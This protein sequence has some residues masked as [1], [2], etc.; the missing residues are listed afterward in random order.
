MAGKDVTLSEDRLVAVVEALGVP[1]DAERLLALERLSHSLP[2]V[3]VV[4]MISRGKSTLVN[5]L[6]GVE[7]CPTDSRG[8]TVANLTISPRPSGFVGQVEFDNGATKTFRSLSRFK[9]NIARSG[10]TWATMAH[11]DVECRL[12]PEVRLVDTPGVDDPHA[13]A[14]ALTLD[15]RWRA[16]GASGAVVVT[17]Y[18]PGV[19]ASDMAVIEEAFRIFGKNVVVV[20]K[21]TTSAVEVSDLRDVATS[22]R[23][24]FHVLPHVLGEIEP[25]EIGEWGHGALSEI[26]RSISGLSVGLSE[27]EKAEAKEIR[28]S[29]IS[30]AKS[31]DEPRVVAAMKVTKTW[32]SSHQ[33]V[34]QLD[35]TLSQR[36]FTLRVAQQGNDERLR[37]VDAK[38]SQFQ[39]SAELRQILKN[40][41]AFQG[42]LRGESL[43]N[44]GELK[45]LLSEVVVAVEAG[46]RWASSLVGALIG[47]R[48]ADGRA[49]MIGRVK[50]SRSKKDCKNLGIGVNDLVKSLSVSASLSLI[51]D[52]QLAS[53]IQVKFLK[54]VLKGNH[55]ELAIHSIAELV[56]KGLP[57]DPILALKSL[58]TV[59]DVCLEAKTD[60]NRLESIS[61]EV[62]DQ[63]IRL[64]L[65][66]LDGRWAKAAD[67]SAAELDLLV[68]D[69]RSSLPAIVDGLPH[70]SVR[71]APDSL[72]QRADR[73][74][75]RVAKYGV[76]YKSALIRD[77]DSAVR[78]FAADS[79]TISRE[80]VSKTLSR[81]AD[82]EKLAS[83]HLQDTGEGSS[84]DVLNE[85]QALRNARESFLVN[86]IRWALRDSSTG[87]GSV[88][89]LLSSTVEQHPNVLNDAEVFGLLL[90]ADP[91]K[92]RTAG[93]PVAK[94]L[95]SRNV[96]EWAGLLAAVTVDEAEAVSLVALAGQVGESST[97]L[98]ILLSWLDTAFPD[99]GETSQLLSVDATSKAV[100]RWQ[101]SKKLS[102]RI[103]SLLTQGQKRLAGEGDGTGWSKFDAGVRALQREFS[104]ARQAGNIL[105]SAH[106]QLLEGQLSDLQ[107]RAA[108]EAAAEE[109][110][111]RSRA[112][113][114][115]N[116]V[117]RSNYRHELVL[118]LADQWV[119][120]DQSTQKISAR[121]VSLARQSFAAVTKAHEHNAKAVLALVEYWVQVREWELRSVPIVLQPGDVEQLELDRSQFDEF[122][123]L[124]S[125]RFG[126]VTADCVGA[127][128]PDSELARFAARCASCSQ[129]ADKAYLSDLTATRRRILRG[130]LP[131]VALL[132]A[133]TTIG[134][135][136]GKQLGDLT[137][138]ED[139]R[140]LQI[141]AAPALAGL[142]WASPILLKMVRLRRS[143]PRPP[144]ASPPWMPL[145]QSVGSDLVNRTATNLH[146]LSAYFLDALQ[147][148]DGQTR[149]P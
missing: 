95:R 99:V 51:G 124:V 12:P 7:I 119:G 76:L 120:I 21:S 67:L 142:L 118:Q 1:V 55:V 138:E 107:A 83:K 125:E 88:L 2:C 108:A 117:V 30:G 29:L 121:Q 98:E 39:S 17:A 4:G 111:K 6:V 15:S 10:D 127:F 130:V 141:I 104:K 82:V 53:P 32:S 86:A 54:S 75:R 66:S 26:E 11:A 47:L 134:P 136:R 18:P 137:V 16:S 133:S 132:V 74:G 101:V 80:H 5:Q 110:I 128:G 96:S 8:E 114:N 56:I 100:S 13:T 3:A 81:A 48:D 37:R 61:G 59:L 28:K 139:L 60:L 147:A 126:L 64:A 42:L 123:H 24:R 41:S 91:G 69:S 90:A 36:L 58:P 57:R 102:L 34:T 131:S 43:T 115:G 149:R 116:L 71:H 62:A 44:V 73:I 68:S 40:S 148:S 33:I 20:V 45:I 145:G 84:E 93:V 14:Q 22:V 85:L 31:A 135:L 77:L 23:D 78:A 109:L 140:A 25:S 35:T 122:L 9:S 94:L 50:R 38:K 72:R 65:R 129:Q 27:E 112:L 46:D 89:Q 97:A 144:W 49:T 52:V 106:L 87:A 146:L 79:Q 63:V 113:E 92:R 70:L 143:Y 103:R 105:D 19:G